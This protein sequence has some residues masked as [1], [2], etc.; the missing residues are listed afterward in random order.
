MQKFMLASFFSLICAGIGYAQ[1]NTESVEPTVNVEVVSAAREDYPDGSMMIR[2]KLNLTLTNNS[3]KKLFLLPS[4]FNVEGINIY[5]R[6]FQT[7]KL[8]SIFHSSSP[9]SNSGNIRWISIGEDLA[10]SN[11]NSPHL[12]D[13]GPKSSYTFEDQYPVFFSNAEYSASYGGIS[14]EKVKQEKGLFFQFD[15]RTWNSE[16]RTRTISRQNFPAQLSNA[17]KKEGTLWVDNILTRPIAFDVKS[18]EV[19]ARKD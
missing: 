3:G 1:I 8:Q 11:G 15:V 9:P 7:K 12:I 2:F 5:K 14:A 6:N 13:L 16:I 19:M 18:V 10:N 4:V 17:L